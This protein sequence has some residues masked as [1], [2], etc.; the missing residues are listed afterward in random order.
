MLDHWEANGPPVYISVAAYLN[1][2]GQKSK[3]GGS[4]APS[5]PEEEYG[6]LND[7]VTMF[8]GSGGAIGA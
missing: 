1:W 2:G 5:A 6:N 8:G 7:L 4:E 3:K